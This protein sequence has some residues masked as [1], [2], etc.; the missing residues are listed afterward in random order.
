MDT[1]VVAYY[2]GPPCTSVMRNTCNSVTESAGVL[3]SSLVVGNI[4]SVLVTNEQ[5][6]WWR[7]WISMF[8]FQ[9]WLLKEV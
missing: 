8:H 2:F 1:F 5:A 3:D 7:S 6:P 9:T 4:S